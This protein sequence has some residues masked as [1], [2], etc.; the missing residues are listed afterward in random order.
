MA[1]VNQDLSR[2][3]RV[4]HKPQ[5]GRLR[6]ETCEADRLSIHVQN[7]VCLGYDEVMALFY[8]V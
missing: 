6:L 4:H 2:F 8:D 3:A 1:H 7:Y 5:L